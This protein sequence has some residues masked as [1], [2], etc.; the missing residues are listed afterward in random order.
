MKVDSQKI[1]ETWRAIVKS[2]P[3]KAWVVFENGTCVILTDGISRG[4]DEAAKAA[5]EIVSVFGPLC[6]GTPAGDFDVVKCTD[7]EGWIV[8][9][10]H[11]DMLNFVYSAEVDNSNDRLEIGL[12]GRSRRNDD[13]KNPKVIHVEI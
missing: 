5:T 8:T 12:L 6:A 10:H 7:A 1:V 4:K 2:E 3:P 13:G 9:G 11:E